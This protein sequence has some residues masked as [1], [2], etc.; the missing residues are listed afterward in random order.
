MLADE[1]ARTDRRGRSAAVYGARAALPLDFAGIRGTAG[2]WTAQ[3]AQ[4]WWQ[5]L[6]PPR[7]LIWMH[8]LAR[9]WTVPFHY[10]HRFVR[11]A[12]RAAT[13]PDLQS[14]RRT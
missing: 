8:G 7:H 5:I 3:A 10:V 4:L 13:V 14:A 1:A 2:G 11:A 6:P 12:R 9:P